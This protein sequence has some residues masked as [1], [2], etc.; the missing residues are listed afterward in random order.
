[1]LGAMQNMR[2]TEGHKIAKTENQSHRPNKQNETPH[3]IVCVCYIAD[4]SSPEC[5]ASMQIMNRQA[6]GGS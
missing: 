6:L 1:M 3:K 4:S 5:G 2:K